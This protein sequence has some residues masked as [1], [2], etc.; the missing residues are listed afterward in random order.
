M[1]FVVKT[2]KI[3]KDIDFFHLLLLLADMNCQ[4]QVFAFNAYERSAL[5]YQSYF[6]DNLFF[7]LCLFTGLL[8]NKYRIINKV[9]FDAY[10]C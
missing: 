2:I 9:D 10:N 1:N 8:P 6:S 4:N 5:K 7:L 3:H